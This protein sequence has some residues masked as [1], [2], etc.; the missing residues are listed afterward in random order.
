ML[1]ISTRHVKDCVLAGVERCCTV[2]QSTP[3]TFLRTFCRCHAVQS[4]E[5]GWESLE[6][7][8]GCLQEQLPTATLLDCEL[9]EQ[10]CTVLSADFVP[11]N[12]AVLGVVILLDEADLESWL[13]CLPAS[14]SRWLQNTPDSA[15]PVPAAWDVI[16]VRKHTKLQH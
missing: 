15:M 3:S 2:V 8:R 4:L 14:C 16:E 10:E 9:L 6:G 12:E 7:A 5:P 11:N 13:C 1:H